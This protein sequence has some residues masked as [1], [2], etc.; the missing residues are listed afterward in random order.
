MDDFYVNIVDPLEKRKVLLQ[1]SRVLIGCLRGL[2]EFLASKKEKKELLDE[3]LS[4]LKAI[5]RLNDKLKARLPRASV[6]G[7]EAPRKKFLHEN[8]P[9]VQPLEADVPKSKLDLLEE[10]LASIEEKLSR[11]G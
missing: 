8:V 11:L 2:D 10:E 3:F 1:S 7:K 4:T 9:F 5:S 6:S